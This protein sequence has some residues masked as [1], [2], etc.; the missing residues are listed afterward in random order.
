MKSRRSL[1]PYFW[2]FGALFSGFLEGDGSSW[3]LIRLLLG[4]AG[5]MVIVLVAAMM[6]FLLFS[7]PVF[8]PE[9]TL[10]QIIRFVG[11]LFSWSSLRFLL[12]PTGVF[13]LVVMV[14]GRYVQDVYD[15]RSYGA[16][17]EYLLNCLFALG[18]PVLKVRDGKKELKEGE[19]NT[20]DIIGG[21]G[22]VFVAPGNAVLF[23][24]ITHPSK[25]VPQGR[26]FITRY[27][28][29]SDIVD[30]TDQHGFIEKKSAMSKDGIIVTVHNVQFRYRTVGGHRHAGVTGRTPK[31]PYPFSVRAIRNIA[32]ARTATRDGL[33]NWN[34]TISGR[35]EGEILNYIRRSQLDEVISGREGQ[36]TVREAI[37]ANLQSAGFRNRLAEIGTELLWFDIGYITFEEPVVEEDMIKV[38]AAPIAGKAEVNKAEGDIQRMVQMDMAR[39]RAQAEVLIALMDSF[40]ETQLDNELSQDTFAKLFLFKVGNVLEGMTNTTYMPNP[41]GE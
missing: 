4:L 8:E 14:S 22:Y 27:E 18:A 41:D 10:D 28:R 13:V 37:R 19:E 33:S 24:S 15:L 29:L 17:I 12:F 38:W 1:N 36:Q 39:A 7:S 2:R 25:V 34:G 23:E 5:G 31:N 32:Y 6:E 35:V 21:P 26:Y 3:G 9:S 11:I 30:L 16:S 20:L 40:K